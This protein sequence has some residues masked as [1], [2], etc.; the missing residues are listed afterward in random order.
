MKQKRSEFLKQQREDDK[1]E[2]E[3]RLSWKLASGQG[4]LLYSVT[5][6][7]II[8]AILKALFFIRAKTMRVPLA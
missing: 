6:L 8:A 3:K 1:H 7:A 2:D 5:I 4:D